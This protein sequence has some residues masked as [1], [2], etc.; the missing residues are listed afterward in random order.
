ML[1]LKRLILAAI[2]V[3]PSPSYAH[4]AARPPLAVCQ[5][6]CGLRPPARLQNYVPAL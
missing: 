6:P 1:K 2:E 3:C 5:N 4:I